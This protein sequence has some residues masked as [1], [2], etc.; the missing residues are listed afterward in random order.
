MLLQSTQPQ[1]CGPVNT[2]VERLR[3]I[4]AYLD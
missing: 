4:V 1:G 3:L 2:N